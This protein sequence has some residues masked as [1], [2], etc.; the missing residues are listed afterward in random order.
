[1]NLIYDRQGRPIEIKT[2][3]T[4]AED[5]AY[6][7]VALDWIPYNRFEV[8]TVWLGVDH[9]FGD[10][11]RP[12]IFETMV[13][14]EGNWSSLDC[15][16]YSSE[17]EALAGHVRMLAY[18]RGKAAIPVHLGRLTQEAHWRLRALTRKVRL[19]WQ[20]HKG[21]WAARGTRVRY[22]RR[23]SRGRRRERLKRMRANK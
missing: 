13:F 2:Y 22:Q 7:C 4:L 19:Q 16:R 3:V 14:S 17:E 15:A 20:S 8:S 21:W 1:M 9:R 12:L 5:R 10:P 18:W 6:R 23:G 11:G